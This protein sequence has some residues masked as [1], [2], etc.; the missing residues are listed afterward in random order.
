VQ[1]MGT[2]TLESCALHGGV[3]DCRG[4]NGGVI[5]RHPMWSAD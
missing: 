4:G 5:P 2:G 3:D 1:R